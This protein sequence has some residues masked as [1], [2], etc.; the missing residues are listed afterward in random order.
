MIYKYSILIYKALVH[1][2]MYKWHACP[3]SDKRSEEHK[4]IVHESMYIRVYSYAQ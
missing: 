1:E 4:A 2:Y 3:G